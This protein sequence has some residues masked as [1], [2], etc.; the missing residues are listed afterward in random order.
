VLHA[1]HLADPEDA[2]TEARRLE[3]ALAG[4]R[5]SRFAKASRNTSGR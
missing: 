5:Q 3:A 2:H 1:F 4:P